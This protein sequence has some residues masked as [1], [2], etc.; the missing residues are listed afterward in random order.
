MAASADTPVA[1]RSPSVVSLTPSGTEK[2]HRSVAA[3]PTRFF[4]LLVR[5][6]TK[7]ILSISCLLQLWNACKCCHRLAA[8][9]MHACVFTCNVSHLCNLSARPHVAVVAELPWYP[10]LDLPEL[11]LE[12]SVRP[13]FVCIESK[14]CMRPSAKPAKC[15]SSSRRMSKSCPNPAV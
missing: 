9:C 5:L 13:R 7:L 11:R 12:S 8:P 3:S 1:A 15:L 10:N 2:R 6:Q 4:E 14:T